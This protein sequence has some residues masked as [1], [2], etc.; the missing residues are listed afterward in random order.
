MMQNQPKNYRMKTLQDLSLQ[1]L[2][3]YWYATT[4]NLINTHLF[5]CKMQFAEEIFRDRWSS[6]V[7][8]EEVS[9]RVGHREIEQERVAYYRDR[10]REKRRS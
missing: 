1:D 4:N 9:C 7:G 2:I 8:A 3:Q 10:T 6:A 5:K